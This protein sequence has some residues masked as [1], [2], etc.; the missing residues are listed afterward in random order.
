MP[1]NEALKEMI[2]SELFTIEI[3]LQYLV[4]YEG[5]AEVISLLVKRL[6]THNRS[7]VF[8]YLPEFIF[9]SIKSNC[10]EMIELLTSL[11]AENFN[12]FFL[13][14]NCFEIWGHQISI[15]NNSGKIKIRSILEE[16]ENRMVNGGKTLVQSANSLDGEIKIN[17]EELKNIVIGKRTKNDFKDEIRNFVNFLVRLSYLIL[18]NRESDGKALAVECLHKLNLE[19]FKRRANADE[20]M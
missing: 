7:A 5:N 15:K 14:T 3:L 16:C 20:S 12:Q 1:N 4:R 10:T 9:F 11:A 13:I 8:K 6:D 19:L 18:N 17:P 2:N